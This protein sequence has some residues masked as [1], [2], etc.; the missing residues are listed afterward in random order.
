MTETWRVRVFE[1]EAVV[2]EVP[3]A[4]PLE[5]GRQRD[6]EPA[7]YQLLAT[8]SGTA[9]LVIAPQEARADTSRRHLTITPVR[10]GRIRVTNH[11]QAV[12]NCENASSVAVG[13]FV[14]LTPP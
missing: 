10:E 7:P 13:D 3:L 5:I 4:A 2:F 1:G 9:R 11:S 12:L 6:G 14:E 8:D